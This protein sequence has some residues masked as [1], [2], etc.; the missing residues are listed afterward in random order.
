[1][2]AI[3]GQPSRNV[4]GLGGRPI[5]WTPEAIQAEIEE[6]AEWIKNPQNIFLE[7][8]S[9]SRGYASTRIR[10]WQKTHADLDAHLAYFFEKQKIALIKG[11]LTKKMFYPMCALMLSCNHNMSLKTEQ[12]INANV[13]NRTILDDVQDQTKDLID[14]SRD[15]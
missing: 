3:K 6:F 15:S 11:G 7:D 2:A 13:N 8:F 12:S 5:K 10:E 4:N 9:Q 1:M 14:E